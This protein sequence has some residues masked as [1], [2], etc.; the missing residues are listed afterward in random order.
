MLKAG[1]NAQKTE[2][3]GGGGVTIEPQSEDVLEEDEPPTV[4][5][6]GF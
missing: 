5:D 3:S 1:S 6:R 4:G 2:G